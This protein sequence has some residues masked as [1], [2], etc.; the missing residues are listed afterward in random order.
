MHVPTGW[1]RKED[2][3]VLEQCVYYLKETG[4]SLR[5]QVGSHLVSWLCI[6][7]S[8]LLLAGAMVTWLQLEHVVER[9][10]DEAD[11]SF[12]VEDD[13]TEVQLARLAEEVRSY[14]GVT[15]VTVV[16]EAEALERM[17]ALLGERQQLLTAFEEINP[18]S[19]FIE[20][21][22]IP[23]AA[24][25]V[26]RA[27][28]QLAGVWGVRANEEVLRGLVNLTVVVRGLG[29]ALGALVGLICVVLI[30]H[31]IRLGVQLR[32]KEIAVL[33]LLGASE[34]FITAPFL[35]EGVFIGTVGAALAAV[36]ATIALSVMVSFLE[37]GIPFLPLLTGADLMGTL[38]GVLLVLGALS[39]AIGSLLGTRRSA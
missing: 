17:G 29:M 10:R 26:T 11:I 18:F 8:L 33:R 12:F 21:S 31:I 36:L 28:E 22:V 1:S 24:E 35:L 37:Q 3:R 13:V 15:G 14:P 6:S 23:E 16:S 7:L 27:G 32:Q 4:R 25:A 30:S 19:R 5:R 38:T 9:V 2:V 34:S 20:I 39:G